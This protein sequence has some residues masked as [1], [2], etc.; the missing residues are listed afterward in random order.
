MQRLNEE[1][2]GKLTL[3]IEVFKGTYH[4]GFLH[5]LVSSQLDMDRMDYLMRDSFYTGVSEGV[6]GADR[7]IKMLNVAN[8]SLVVEEKGIYSIEK[9]LVARRLMYW[10]VYLHK[11]VVAAE[12]QLLLLLKRSKEL[13]MKGEQLF[14]TPAFNHFFNPKYYQ[15]KL[16]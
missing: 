2:D 10:Q 14:A 1:F 15:R 7:I 5:Q 8:G 6:I 12:I 13:V 16:F 4:K 11:T 9:F 3:A